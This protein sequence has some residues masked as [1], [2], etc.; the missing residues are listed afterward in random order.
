MLQLREHLVTGLV[1]LVFLGS[2]AIG[3][4]LLYHLACAGA[5]RR[6]ADAGALLV[7]LRGDTRFQRQM[8]AATLVWGLGLVGS[9][10]V[11]SALVF[12]L[13]IKQFLLVSGPIGYTCLGLLTAWTFW[14]VPRAVRQALARLSL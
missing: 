11:Q 7:A 5:A 3:Q 4:P 1:G 13:T 8:L 10:A 6:S 2:I 14:F 12:M 9:C